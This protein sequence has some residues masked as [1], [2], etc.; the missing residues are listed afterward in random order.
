PPPAAATPAVPTPTAPSHPTPA[1]PIAAPPPAPAAPPAPPAPPPP[2]LTPSAPAVA[3]APPVASVPPAPAMPPPPASAPVAPAA[4]PAA[5]PSP[6][7]PASTAETLPR[8]A[9]AVPVLPRRPA[10]PTT[11]Q[12]SRRQVPPWR[13]PWI[14]AA[15]VLALF[16]GGWLLAT[17]QDSRP[18]RTN[19]T[20]GR[21]SGALHALGLGGPR[22]TVTVNSRPP[23][24]WITL[25]GNS[26]TVR[27]P[28]E[29]S[30]TPG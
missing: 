26:P 17:L 11:Q 23:G 8:R 29:L 13:R 27:T 10:W 15:G 1:P 5:P 14:L 22:F 3:P 7:E 24:A 21:W 9:R 2:A 19:A 6:A 4:S 30:L 16:A 28:A 20:E 18:S 12:L 25:D